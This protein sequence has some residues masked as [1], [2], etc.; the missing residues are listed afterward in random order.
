MLVWLLKGAMWSESTQRRLEFVAPILTI[1]QLYDER[2]SVNNDD[3]H[4][5]VDEL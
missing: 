3:I 2:R 1:H 4:G 5:F